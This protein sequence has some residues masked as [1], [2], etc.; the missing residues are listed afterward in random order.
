MSE[1]GNLKATGIPFELDGETIYLSPNSA[2]GK[3]LQRIQDTEPDDSS[4]WI[5]HGEIGEKVDVEA[6]NER[7]RQRGYKIQVSF[8]DAPED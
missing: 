7:L 4:Q 8:S 5:T 2:E 3:A 6:I 1:I